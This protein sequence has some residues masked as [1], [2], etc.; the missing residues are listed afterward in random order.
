MG[1][2]FSSNNQQSDKVFD[3]KQINAIHTRLQSLEEVDRNQDG[4]ITKDEFLDWK[5]RQQEDLQIFRET[6]IKMKDQ[7]YAEKLTELQKQVEALKEINTN[8]EFE[9]K[10]ALQTP[11]TPQTTTNTVVKSEKKNR[12]FSQAS[13][14]QIQ[15]VIDRMI[16][17]E[18]V[19]IK[20]LPDFVEKQLYKNVFNIVLGLLNELV[21]GSSIK[22][23]GHEITLNMN[24]LEV[25]P[26][27][28]ESKN[29]SQ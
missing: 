17:N 7:E 21:E 1:N 18:A 26:I 24:A 22:L 11:Q 14:L 25:S 19:N 4:L 27:V 10:Q 15:G 2:L 16:Q 6:I 5:R 12:P 28:D 8:L 13:K 3:L 20:Y 29:E 9:L 23:I